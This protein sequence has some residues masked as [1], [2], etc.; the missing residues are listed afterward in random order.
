MPVITAPMAAQGLAHISAEI[1]TARG[2]DAAGTLMTVSTFAHKKI[3]EIA[4]ATKGP[5]WFLHNDRGKSRELLQRAKAAGYSAVVFTIDAFGLGSSDD[6]T[7]LTFTFPPGLTFVNSNAAELK[8]S[9]SWDDV[10]FIQQTT[11]L[12]LIL[13]GILTA[14]IA[15]AGVQ[16]G[17]AAIQ[18]SNH[19]GRQ[20][21]GSQ[22]AL[23]VLPSVVAAVGGR[24][25]I[26]MDSGIRRGTDVFKALALGANAVAMGRTVLYGLSLGGSAGVKSVYDRLR[27]ELFRT[28]TIAGVSKISDIKKEYLA[29]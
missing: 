12:P 7:R 9:L 14:D 5:K 4:A 20:L 11:D 1:G 17:A 23:D 26:I 10:D 25:P 18:V 15:I 21:D 24:V 2:T 28:M 19:G 8:R 29:S 27:D 16:R 3:E 13:K 6:V 22:A